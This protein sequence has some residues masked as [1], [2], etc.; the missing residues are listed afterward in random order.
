MTGK[1]MSPDVKYDIHL[2]NADE[3]TRLS[4]MSSIA[5]S[6]E[7]NKQFIALLT[8]NRFVLSTQ[9]SGVAS[10]NT[11]STSPYSSA[12]GVNASEFLSNQLSHWLSQI[13]NDLDIGVN[14]RTNREMKSNEVQIALSTQLFNDKLTINSS[15]DVATNAAVKETD[16]IVGEFD[17]D[18]KITR[19]GKLRLK[20][21][22]HA[23]NDMLYDNPYTQ[24]LGI[25]YRED[26]DT[27]GELWR[28]YLRAVFGKKEEEPV[29]P[30]QPDT[31]GESDKDG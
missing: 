18:Y 29:V 21:Y 10:L 17:I 15:L 12:A 8:L 16:N 1:L 27:L 24:G 23:N 14:Y 4:V 31:P 7:L 30:S 13:N 26:F 28:D 19:N 3:K 5:T 20:T 22:N 2:P 25:F 9:R 11:S 6:E